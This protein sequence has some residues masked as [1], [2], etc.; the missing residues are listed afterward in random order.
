VRD[1][2]T[3]AERLDQLVLDSALRRSMGARGRG[4]FEEHFTLNVFHRSM[5]AAFLG[6]F[7]RR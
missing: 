6:L 2:N 3:L 7:D 4:I 5:G 1:A